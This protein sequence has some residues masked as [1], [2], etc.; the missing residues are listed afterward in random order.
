MRCRNYHMFHTKCVGMGSSC[1]VVG[2]GE[3][4][5]H[6]VVEAP[7]QQG[8]A[9]IGAGVYSSKSQATQVSKN[10]FPSASAGGASSLPA[11]AGAG[12]STAG[13]SSSAAKA[14]AGAGAG[15]TAG[16][17]SSAAGVSSSAA[18]A[19]AGAAAAGAGGTAG[20]S[21]SAAGAAAAGVSSSAAGAGGSTAG[22]SSSAAK[23]AAA[24]A[25]AGGTSSSPQVTDRDVALFMLNAQYGA[26]PSPKLTP[27]NSIDPSESFSGM[28]QSQKGKPSLP[29]LDGSQSP[30]FAGSRPDPSLS[31]L[32]RSVSL[33][34]PLFNAELE[35]SVLTYMSPN[36]SLVRYNPSTNERKTVRVPA[37]AN[38]VDAV[39]VEAQ[40]T[41]HVIGGLLGVK[42]YYGQKK[43]NRVLSSNEVFPETGSMSTP[44]YG[45]A[46][47]LLGDHIYVSG[48]VGS[49]SMEKYNCQTGEW[50]GSSEMGFMRAYHQL[51]AVGESLYALGGKGG[52]TSTLSRID[53]F[54]DGVWLAEVARMHYARS[55]FA[56]VEGKQKG[57]IYSSGGVGSDGKPTEQCEVFNAAN[58]ASEAFPSLPEPRYGHAMARAGSLLYV[59]GGLDIHHNAL[60]SILSCD[61]S[62]PKLL[63]S[64]SVMF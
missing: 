39:V 46:G 64:W 62:K 52:F 34:L 20:V 60:D 53:V 28:S 49:S 15:G 22:S 58:N 51:L 30:S 37:L 40:T 59:M 5:Y 47:A 4:V 35:P 61:T 57:M 31:Q 55:N 33:Q 17:S 27:I 10:L 6:E 8:S 11:A 41:L 3:Y 18:K 43:M 1:T 16:V 56:A 14:A 26:T 44:R 50:S 24:G 21:S 23:A 9:N 12:G 7:A 29:G 63:Q 48:G 38:L 45:A 19:A 36:G 13:S 42:D 54:K 2:C 32:P 25:A